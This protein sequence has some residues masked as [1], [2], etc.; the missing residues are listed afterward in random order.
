ML[1][2]LGHLQSA[3]TSPRAW[4]LVACMAGMGQVYRATDVRLPL[5]AAS[6][7]E[8]MFELA[9]IKASDPSAYWELMQDDTG[10]Q[11]SCHKRQHR[12]A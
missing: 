4:P 1:C 5:C 12:P 3:T 10:G 11:G 8:A 9:G 2:L 6:T 7:A